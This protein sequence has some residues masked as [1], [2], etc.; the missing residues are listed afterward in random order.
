M[1]HNR[2]ILEAKARND[3]KYR[4]KR[5]PNKIL[6]IIELSINVTFRLVRLVQY[7]R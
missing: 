7:I 6:A 5:L 3:L 1:L 4:T 2:L